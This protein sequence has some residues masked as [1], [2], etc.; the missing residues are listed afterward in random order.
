MAATILIIEDR[1]SQSFFL[2]QQFEELGYEVLT[3][4]TGKEGLGLFLT[5]EV[6]VVLLDWKLPDTRGLEV[7]Q[8]IRKDDD[9]VP[10][11]MMTAFAEVDVAVDAMQMGAFEYLRKPVDLAELQRVVERALE[12]LAMKRE[13][14]RLQA[15]GEAGA[16]DWI[17]GNNPEMR[18]VA[19]IVERVAPTDASVLIEGESGTGK[20]VVAREIHRRSLRSHRP[21]VA[22][23]CAAIPDQLLESE[24]FGFEAGAF[25]GARRQKKGLLETADGG[26]VFLD[27]ISSM[28]LEMQAKILRVLEDKTLR[29]V[30]GNTDIRV[31]VRFISASNKSLAHAIEEGTFR[32]DLYWRLSVIPL[33]LIP[34][35]ERKSDIGLFVAAFIEH[36]NRTTGK[37]IRGISGEA[38]ELMR[39]YHWPGNIR[40]LR[41]V[42]ERAVILCDGD[43]IRVNHLP[44]EIASLRVHPAAKPA[45]APAAGRPEAVSAPAVPAVARRCPTFD[46]ETRQMLREYLRTLPVGP[47]GGAEAERFAESPV[48]AQVEVLKALMQDGQDYHRLWLAAELLTPLL[49]APSRLEALKEAFRQEEGGYPYFLLALGLAYE[50]A[51]DYASALDYLFQSLAL[52]PQC[53]FAYYDLGWV[54]RQL[55]RHADA[56]N[57]LARA[58]EIRPDYVDAFN[59]LGITYFEQGDYLR[60]LTA[61]ESA[62][63]HEP[64]NPH[65]YFN[66]GCV[67]KAMGEFDAAAAAFARALELA[68]DYEEAAAQLRVVERAAAL[69]QLEVL[70]RVP[71]F[72]ELPLEQRLLVCERLEAVTHGEGEVIIRQG[73]PGDAFYIVEEGRLEVSI[74]GPQG[75]EVVVRQLEPGHYFGEIALMDEGARRTATVRAVTPVRLMRLSREAFDQVGAEIPSVVQN[76]V[77]TRN[78]RLRQDVL[79]TLEGSGNG[80]ASA[81]GV[82]TR[83]AGTEDPHRFSVLMAAVHPP[84]PQGQALAGR[85]MLRFLKEFYFEMVNV[86]GDRG[87][88]RQYT[89]DRLVALFDEPGAAVGV[90]ME[91]EATF[92]RL[93][94]R[95]ERE[96]QAV[97][98]LSV[99]I[100]TGPL[101][102]EPEGQSGPAM[103]IAQG[104]CQAGLE[105]GGLLADEATAQALA[106]TPLADR[107]APL[108]RPVTLPGMEEP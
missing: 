104:L 29:R 31:D 95:W 22:I 25:T 48:E 84:A 96:N 23:N 27:E 63:A 19:R 81:A 52:Q 33:R 99:G 103:S 92:A 44:T 10:V 100:A 65:H 41:N 24:L 57:S 67:Q 38:L 72:K 88:V 66:V 42:I 64:E 16:G 90:A 78:E 7:L 69:P 40:E 61:F 83:G 93:A 34:L 73:D 58:L 60:A 39:A 6:D 91:M 106:G 86:I 4:E 53:H 17:V 98:R 97:P 79:R 50:G 18:R 62:M 54:Q 30:G 76:L 87:V 75:E 45:E 12:T 105:D 35:R 8:E 47:E 37:S 85:A 5:H 68:P 28:P 101:D 15:G 9:L 89:G 82:P 94:A 55:G 102:L 56:A 49:E 107:C 3:A 2:K 71:F 13:L 1:K 51:G 80:K 77:Q 74:V 59:E 70:D 46:E 14:R 26:T 108:A 11:I 43:E 32:E 21:F 36:F 20:E